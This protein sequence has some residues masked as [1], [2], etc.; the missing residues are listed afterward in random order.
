MGQRRGTLP[1]GAC[2]TASPDVEPVA[3]R[4]VCGAV[5]AIG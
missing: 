5:R 4:S 2:C 3:E 1:V